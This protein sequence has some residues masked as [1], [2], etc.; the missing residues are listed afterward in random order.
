MLAAFFFLC[1]LGLFNDWVPKRLIDNRPFHYSLKDMEIHDEGGKYIYLV[2]LYF[3]QDIDFINNLGGYSLFSKITPT[4]MVPSYWTIGPAIL[5]LPFFAVGDLLF[6][7]YDALGRPLGEG[8]FSIPYFNLQGLGAIVYGYLALLFIYQIL[9]K[10]HTPRVSLLA[11]LVTYFTMVTPYYTFVRC[12]MEHGLEPFTVGFVLWAS[13]RCK[14]HPGQKPSW[15]LLGAASGIASIVRLNG[16][17]IFVPL[18]V[19]FAPWLWRSIQKR[20][21]PDESTLGFKPMALFLA[22]F[23]PFYLSQVWAYGIL[24]GWHPRVLLFFNDDPYSGSSIFS[25]AHQDLS[26]SLGNLWNALLGSRYGMFWQSPIFPV[27]LAGLGIAAYRRSAAAAAGLAYIGALLAML[28]RFPTWGE[29][30][31]YRYSCCLVPFVALGVAEVTR[32]ISTKGSIRRGFWIGCCLLLVAWSYLQ[33]SQIHAVMEYDFP[34]FTLQAFR[35]IPKLIFDRPD[36]LLHST[37]LAALLVKTDF[38]LSQIADIHSLL[39]VPGLLLVF[40][41]VIH[42]S[43]LWLNAHELRLWIPTASLLALGY[44]LWIILLVHP[45]KTDGEIYADLKARIQLI[46][47]YAKAKYKT[48]HFGDAIGLIEQ[49][50]RML[51]QMG[52]EKDTEL[53]WLE[54][55]YWATQNEHEKVASLYQKLHTQGVRNPTLYYNLAA[56]C[57][58]LQHSE[59][60]L[61]WYQEGLRLHPDDGLLHLGMGQWLMSQG[62]F[63]EGSRWIKKAYA[64]DPSLK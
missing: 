43:F 19:L 34:Q 18:F 31:G 25:G 10:N 2:S 35:N 1:P 8:P 29:S 53:D 3:D 5:W 4:G 60:A 64:F 15:L 63:D 33:L 16:Y 47:A 12:R 6:H 55:A 36:R 59:E 56:S 14:Q 23:L 22:A 13:L 9:R 51:P 42:G 39:V 54:A 32:R 17:L 45:K 27:G 20:N 7:F 30:Y 28:T 58:H 44:A 48:V 49:A 62:R 46:T 61:R 57:V 40:L 50:R 11:T 21:F 38:R 26:S 37:T 24:F 41:L 52:Y